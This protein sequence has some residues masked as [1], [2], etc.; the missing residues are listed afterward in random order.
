VLDVSV[1]AFF[2]FLRVVGLA[3]YRRALP[4][5]AFHVARIVAT[6]DED[7]GTCVQLTVNQAK[8]EGV[9]ASVL[10]AVVDAR[11][12]DLPEPEREAYLFASAV[13]AKDGSEGELREKVRARF[14]EEGLVELAFAI[15]SSR[16]FPVTKRALGYATSCSKVEVSV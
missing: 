7:C 13:C 12:D 10:R 9:S 15:A 14:G 11:P 1:R 2:K 5:G 4:L 6:R 3:T 8:H 16:V